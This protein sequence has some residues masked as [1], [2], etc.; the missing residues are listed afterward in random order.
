MTCAGTPPA[1]ARMLVQA[2]WAELGRGA[3][4][5]RVSCAA[6]RDQQPARPQAAGQDRPQRRAAAAGVAGAGPAALL[7]DPAGVDLGPAH[8]RAAAHDP[9]RP[10]HRLAAAHPR[11]AVPPRAAPPHPGAAVTGLPRL[12]GGVTRRPASRQALAVAL[13]QIDGLDAVLAPL[14]RWLRTLGRRQP[15]CRALMASHDGI[16]ASTAPTILAEL[17]DTRRFGGRPSSPDYAC[18]QQVKAHQGGNRA[19]LAVAGKLARRVRHTLP[20]LGDAALAPVE[21]LAVAA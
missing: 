9:G 14:D 8:H 21:D 13:G 17:G 6:G 1:R 7:V 3:P 18:Y 5:G 2:T 16:G 20:A 10:A 19:T 4:G 15:G 11:R 12:A